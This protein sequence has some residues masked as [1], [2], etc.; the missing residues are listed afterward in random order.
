MRRQ[1]GVT[2][3]QGTGSVALFSGELR[4]GASFPAALRGP[5]AEGLP[6]HGQEH[7]C[8]ANVQLISR[9]GTDS[10][11]RPTPNPGGQ[12]SK[13]QPAASHTAETHDSAARVAA[14]I[15]CFHT[16][17]CTPRLGP[18]VASTPDL[19]SETPNGRAGALL[20]RYRGRP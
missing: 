5:H 12:P 15:K 8:L 7:G 2:S 4:T 11:Y 17:K 14:R 18:T 10:P 6:R 3:A 16:F 20:H 19:T 1:L 13:E 9:S